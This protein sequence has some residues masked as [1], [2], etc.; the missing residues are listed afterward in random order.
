MDASMQ[1]IPTFMPD[2]IIFFNITCRDFSFRDE[3]FSPKD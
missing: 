1:N 2:G 3:S